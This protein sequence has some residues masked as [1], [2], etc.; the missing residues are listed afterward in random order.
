MAAPSPLEAALD[1]A[2]LQCLARG[3]QL[4]SLRREVLALILQSPT[5]LT[6]YQLLNQLRQHRQS[7][8]PPTIYR[9][10]DFLLGH[11]LIHRI[12][13]LNAFV[14]CAEHAHD[15]TDAQFL[16]CRACGS[17]TEIEDDAI[18]QALTQAARARGFQPGRAI[19]E[20]D[21]LCAACALNPA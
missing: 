17:V 21:G 15:H 6:A 10:L 1:T 4:T 2:A 14:P 20:L 11:H 18:T 16:I 9:A 7:A 19:I 5:P 12:E 13:R 8:V 3:A